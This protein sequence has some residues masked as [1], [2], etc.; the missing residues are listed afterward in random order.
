MK[1][2]IGLLL[3][4]FLC[5]TSFGATQ[6]SLQ[7]LRNV[8]DGNSQ[9]YDS[10]SLLIA[11]L[12]DAGDF[13]H[14][15]TGALKLSTA[16]GSPMDN[17]QLYFLGGIAD[18]NT[19]SFTIVGWRAENGPAEFIA[20]GN[21]ILGGQKVLLYPETGLTATNRLWVDTIVLTDHEW[22]VDPVVGNNAENGVASLIIKISGLKYFW[23]YITNADN[24]TT[25]EAGY[26]RVYWSMFED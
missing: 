20:S 23:V 13:A 4:L 24:T 19:F 9:D 22:I 17:L 26:I 2:I 8:G 10:N 14:K 21:A 7:L 5:S 18:N 1:K 16:F 11:A 15:P 25:T 12:K 6:R 3:I